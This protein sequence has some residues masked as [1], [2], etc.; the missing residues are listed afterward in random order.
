MWYFSTVITALIDY[1]LSILGRFSPVW[2]LVFFSVVTAIMMLLVFRKVSN[3]E[4]IK[5][6][7]NLIKA[8]FME[9]RLFKNDLRIVVGAQRHIFYQNIRYLRY[10]LAPTVFLLPLIGLLVVELQGWYDYRPLEPGEAALVVVRVKPEAQGLLPRVSLQAGTGLQ[11]ETLGMA[12]PQ[13]DEWAWR[14]RAESPGTH[15]L[16]FQIEGKRIDKTVAVS[17]GRMER[18]GPWRSS[19]WIDE[20]MYPGE[21]PL[22]KASRMERIEVKYPSR[23]VTVAG[24]GIHWMVIFFVLSIVFVLILKGLFGVSL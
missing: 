20:F 1:P 23:T 5:Q 24:W 8:H 14:I 2:S 13:L 6:I 18:V 10:A 4:A 3:Q 9:L 12:T 21:P 22:P 17:Q 7:R 15:K 11:V 19:A 16:E